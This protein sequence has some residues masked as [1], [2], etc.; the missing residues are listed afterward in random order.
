MTFS[1]DTEFPYGVLQQLTPLVRRIIAANPGPF[2]GPGTGTYVVGRG[3]VA[4]IDPGPLDQDHIDRLLDG[5]AGETVSHIL[6]THTHIDHSPGAGPLQRATGAPTYGFGRHGELTGGALGGGDAEFIP[7]IRLR[8]GEKVA[9]DGWSLEALHTP[10]HC[11]NHLCYALAEETALFA[12]DQVMGWSTTVINPPDGNM[13]QYMAALAG[14]KERTDAGLDSIYWPTHG[15][16]IRAPGKRLAE[17][18]E[19]RERRRSRILERLA[20]GDETI[21]AIVKAIYILPHKSLV[22]AAARSVLSQM[23]ELIEEGVVEA[24]GAP[25]IEARYRLLP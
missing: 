9:G 23:L 24:D 19:H 20:A 4:V 7:D 18:I 8:T 14:M 25:T 5:L 10:G 22:P 1:P 16:A 6:I 15:A 21:T 3:R 12:G 11:S 13:T 17:L 2:T